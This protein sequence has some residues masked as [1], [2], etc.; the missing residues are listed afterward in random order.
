MKAE[1]VIQTALFIAFVGCT[2]SAL[3]LITI[4]Y[5]V[6]APFSIYG[7]PV[8]VHI[9]VGFVFLLIGLATLTTLLWRRKKK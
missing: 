9:N 3:G 6:V 7:V 8:E 2:I 5:T 4:V 1:V